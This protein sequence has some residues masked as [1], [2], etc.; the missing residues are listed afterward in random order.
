MTYATT[1]EVCA[2]LRIHEATLARLRR[3]SERA[4]I[5]VPVVRIRRQLRWDT[6]R[7]G[8][9]VEAVDAWARS[10]NA[11]GAT[12]AHPRGGRGIPSAQAPRTRPH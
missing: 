10:R 9:W 12:A 1:A 4:S 7:L 11:R 6:A 2:A 5:P 3:D 8:A